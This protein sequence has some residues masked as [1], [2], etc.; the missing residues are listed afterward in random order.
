MS[1]D[2]ILTFVN[3]T[4][5]ILL[6][7]TGVNVEMS[8]PVEVQ[9]KDTEFLIFSSTGN[10]KGNIVFG[11][12]DNNAMKLSSYALGGIPIAQIDGQVK[13]AMITIGD[14]I[15]RLCSQRFEQSNLMVDITPTVYFSGSDVEV[16][17]NKG[18][19]S[20]INLMSE[21]GITMNVY[22]SIS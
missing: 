5:D 6:Q 10:I 1:K 7:G 12:T 11:M 9:E 3:A 2:T 22:I 13:A 17:T 8:R 18:T 21:D 20:L 4:R 14:T 16:F 15:G 19:N